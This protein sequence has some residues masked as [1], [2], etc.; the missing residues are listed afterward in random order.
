MRR[1]DIGLVTAAT[2]AVAAAAALFAVQLTGLAGPAASVIRVPAGIL[3]VLVLPGYAL[4]AVLLPGPPAHLSPLLWRGM[5]IVGLSLAG[6]VLG[7]LVLN[8]TPAGLTGG[9]W[10]AGLAALTLC[11]LAAS[12]VRRAWHV[13]RGRQPTAVSRGVRAWRPGAPA[14]GTLLTGGCALA[15]VLLAGAATGLAVASAAARHTTGFAQLWLTPTS[16]Y[17]ATGQATLGLR[18]DYRRARDFRVRLRRGAQTIR[19]WDLS[20][21]AGKTWRLSVSV[22]VG[23]SLGAVLTMP[24]HHARP[25]TVHLPARLRAGGPASAR[26][27]R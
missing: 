1:E 15:A 17:S 16:A 8:L 27:G 21:P 12:S 9:T 5:W 4:S 19:T 14:R 3:L 23:Q 26:E 24:G 18:N 25:E 7:G 10:T 2:L 11:A 20:L 22:P 6:A 13:P